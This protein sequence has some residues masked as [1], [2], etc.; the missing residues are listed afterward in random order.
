YT[1][2]VGDSTTAAAGDWSGIYYA[3]TSTGSLD[4]IVLAYGGGASSIS[5][6]LAHFN[7]VEVHQATVRI[8][9]SVFEYNANGLGPNDGVDRSNHRTNDNGVIFVRGS[10]PVIMGNNIRHNEAYAINADVSS[11]N[12]ELVVDWGRS[13]G[14]ADVKP[15]VADNQGILVRNNLLTNNSVNGMVVR[16]G[17]LTTQSVWDDTDIAHVVFDTIYAPDFHTYG[18]IRLESSATQSLVVKLLGQNA[19]FTA[20]GRPLDINDR[21][22][23]MLHVV[24]QPGR[25]VIFTSLH[26]DSVGAGFDQFGAP[27]TDTNNNDDATTPQPGDWRGL[28]IDEYAHDRNVAI[29]VESEANNLSGAGINGTPQT[30]QFLGQLAPR[31]HA[32]DNTRRLG[33]E[34]HGFLSTPS[35]VDVYSFVGEPGTEIWIDMDRTS[36]NLDAVIELVDTDGNVLAR[37]VDSGSTWDYNWLNAD[38]PNLFNVPGLN[39]QV[40]SLRKSGFYD[41][42]FWTTNPRDPGMRLV[43]PGTPGSSPRTYHVRIRSN[44]ENLGTNNSNLS[45]GVTSGVYQFQIRL[46]EQDEFA[47]S[48]I[49]FADIRYAQNGIAVFGQPAHSPLLGESAESPNA[50]NN[51]IQNAQYLGNVFNSERATLGVAGNIDGKND[52]DW[53]KLDL[54]YDSVQAIAGVSD[55]TEYASIIFDMDYAAGTGRVNPVVSIYNSNG[56]LVFTGQ[57][58][59]VND[60]LTHP[61]TPGNPGNAD[62]TRG[63]TGNGDPYLGTIQLPAGT[64]DNPI[65]YYVAIS[66]QAQTP[67]QM[68]QFTKANATNTMTRL[69][70]IDSIHRIVEDHIN[71][72]TYSTALPPDSTS[73]LRND[74]RKEFH[75]SDFTIFAVHPDSTQSSRIYAI[76]PFTG[77]TDANI[78]AFGFSVRDLIQH[79]DGKVYAYNVDTSPGAFRPRDANSGNFIQI[80]TG[81]GQATLVR[82]DGVG[83]YWRPG[84]EFPV[85]TQLTDGANKN[86]GVGY[87]YQFEATGILNGGSAQSIQMYAIGNRGD[88]SP[89]TGLFDQDSQFTNI[90]FQMDASDTDGNGRPIGEASSIS[91]FKAA[92]GNIANSDRSP[93][94]RVDTT[95]DAGGASNAIRVVGA[96]GF[97]EFGLTSALLLDGMNFTVDPGTGDVIFELDFGAD[98]QF[99]L[100]PV[101]GQFIRDNEQFELSGSKDQDFI[102]QTGA[103]LQFDSFNSGNITE[104][105]EGEGFTL[106]DSTGTERRFLLDVIGSD[107]VTL[108]GNG[109]RVSVAAG[110]G[111][112]AVAQAI[113]DAID[114]APSFN[115]DA[116][117]GPD[118]RITLEG[119]KSYAPTIAGSIFGGMEA[120][121]EYDR[122]TDDDNIIIDVEETFTSE[123]VVAA[124]VN[125][126]DKANES[127]FTDIDASAL[128]GSSRVSFLESANP[129]VSVAL[130]ASNIDSDSLD[131]DVTASSGVTAGNIR[132]P[133]GAGF[134]A[135]QIGDAIVE[136]ANDNTVPADNDISSS[137]IDFGA[138]ADITVPEETPF[139]VGGQAPGGYITGTAAIGNQ[140]YA[141]TNT[142]GLFQLTKAS[143]GFDVENGII[144]ADYI[145]TAVGLLDINFSGLTAGPASTASSGSGIVGN[146]SYSDILFGSTKTGDIYAFDATGGF[147][148]IFQGD[149]EKISTGINNLHGIEFG[150]LNRNLWQITDTREG[151][152]GHGLNVPVTTSRIGQQGGLSMH[153]GNEANAFPANAD[154]SEWGN[155]TKGDYNLPGSAHG[156]VISD[157]FNL[158]GYN[159]AD[160]PTLY[161]NYFLDTDGQ[162]YVPQGGNDIP[163]TDAFRVFAA[164]DD[165]VW[166]LLATNDGY[167]SADTSANPDDEFDT[168]GNSSKVAIDETLREQRQNGTEGVQELFDNTGWRQARVD[169]SAFAGLENIRLRFDFSTGGSVNLGGVSQAD[170]R[171]YN[172]QEIRFMDGRKHNDGET[173]TITD[174]RTG[175]PITFELDKGQSFIFNTGAVIVQNSTFTLV[176]TDS[177]DVHVFEFVR[178]LGDQAA[179]NIPILYSLSDSSQTI[180]ESVRAAILA[181]FPTVE[182]F[183]EGANRFNIQGIDNVS[184]TIPQGMTVV[185]QVGNNTG[186]SHPLIEFNA[187]TSSSVIATEAQSVI[188]E[189]MA[190]N[191]TS[192]GHEIF[193]RYQEFIYG[194]GY[195]FN[196][197]NSSL[198]FTGSLQGDDFGHANQGKMGDPAANNSTANR[199][200][201]DNLHQGVF[202]DDIII[203][204]AERGEMVTGSTTNSAF[205]TNTNLRSNEN[206]QGEYQLEARRGTDYGVLG[207]PGLTLIRTFNT[208]DRLIQGHSIVAPAGNEIENGFRM[209]VGDGIDSIVFEFFDRDSQTELAARGFA[210]GSTRINYDR[211]R[212]IYSIGY[213]INDTDADIARLIMDAVNDSAGQVS[214]QLITTTQGLLGVRAQVNVRSGTTTRSQVDLSRRTTSDEVI[215]T[216]APGGN[217]TLYQATKTT[218]GVEPVTAG[219]IDQVEI[220]ASIGDNDPLNRWDRYADL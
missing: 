179:G 98:M 12:H 90:V 43:L 19:G 193:N 145:N 76:D 208:N 200:G 51:V 56:Q 38:D 106:I 8:T 139:D 112:N 107:T 73:I 22:G 127:G 188:H 17:T 68:D 7:A 1:K 5:G 150:T 114:N 92:M 83:T 31:E 147:Q 36:H 154:N 211:V 75:L 218:V 70:P 155:A 46:R 34:V 78:G 66:S 201:Q 126:I 71:S 62:L 165:G 11:L 69:E 203:G 97:D 30:P 2:N 14:D 16:G 20:T 186:F 102:F 199:R 111:P 57:G 101:G 152:A 55:E 172:T 67:V 214:R 151:D 48:S 129:A 169:L 189:I 53:F 180:A 119:D 184:G 192:Q 137:V 166:H 141:V 85:L 61:Q 54:N 187:S 130:D 123:Q 220:N 105:N 183:S 50:N 10:Q 72:G 26:D 176:E 44:S 45:G 138:N 174:I 35:D 9:D 110:S 40:N 161:F 82:D 64:P 63:S 18:G 197:S 32:S 41:E 216:Y 209:A 103:V 25:P 207:G 195:T 158:S 28:V 206:L 146:T 60:D 15:G 144:Q 175:T 113:V 185:G 132:V 115:V 168:L 142:G 24:G 74:S 87:G 140:L 116:T 196:V 213:S 178:Q 104:A 58:S 121:G 86:S 148:Y 37:S 177:A 125:A 122:A 108:P 133:V 42:D 164:G 81:N 80:N 181:N 217:D 29:I 162:N 205:G 109:V 117:L 159:A 202:I 134:T 219:R 173:F 163:A 93:V 95:F 23:G 215:L 153:F 157:P 3:H 182:I 100:D 212:G 128:A 27:Q 204:F 47:G 198:G 170:D 39:G 77:A 171:Q 194:H 6:G 49:R 190:P 99:T 4:K 21:I 91:N 135:A 131:P 96:T 124:I 136:A 167:R 160:L 210:G 143:G 94:G 79:P 120:D 89:T 156:S 88:V 33:F 191:A 84:T 149:R 65:H 118:N 13:T 59:N 52:V